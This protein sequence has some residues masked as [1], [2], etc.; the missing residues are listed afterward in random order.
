[1]SEASSD[2][3]CSL[4]PP[5]RQQRGQARLRLGWRGRRGQG[6]LWRGSVGSAASRGAPARMLLHKPTPLV[7]LYNPSAHHTARRPA[8]PLP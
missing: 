3:S 2:C 8:R 5:A 4:S 6:G 1:M 7:H